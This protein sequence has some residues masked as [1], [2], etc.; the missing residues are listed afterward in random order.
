MYLVAHVA[1]DTTQ[2]PVF[3]ASNN[4]N[5]KKADLRIR[6]HFFFVPHGGNCQCCSSQI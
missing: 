1:D 4:T 5:E 3:S 6:K 2:I